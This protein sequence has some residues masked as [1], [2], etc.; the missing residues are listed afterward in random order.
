M[1][2][3]CV[4]SGYLDWKTKLSVALLL[5]EKCGFSSTHA[6]ANIFYFN[7]VLFECK[8][9]DLDSVN[10]FESALL[11]KFSCSNVP[12]FIF[13]S[14]LSALKCF[15]LLCVCSFLTRPLL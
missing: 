14:C 5:Y 10:K 7:V 2:Q 11:W 1:L 3:K 15:F 13:L 9:I 4:C 12:C 8:N 6:R